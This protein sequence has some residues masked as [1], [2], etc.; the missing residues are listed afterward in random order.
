MG[1]RHRGL[2]IGPLIAALTLAACAGSEALVDS[3]TVSL[4][5]VEIGSV[6]LDRQSFRLGFVVSNPNNFP[7]P[8]NEV[9]YKVR[10]GE[11]KFASGTTASNFTIP[12]RGDGT[13]IISVDLDIL[14][15]TSQVASFVRTGMQSDVNYELEGTLAIDIP[16]VRPMSFEN[17]GSISIAGTLY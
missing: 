4:A 11:H 3:P 5:S 1:T 13:F 7:L 10:L 17:E 2:N 12:A 9:K 8:V 6:S 16:Y 15:T 14:N